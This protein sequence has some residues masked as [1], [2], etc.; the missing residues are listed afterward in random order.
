MSEPVRLVHVITRLDL[1]GAQQNTLHCVAH[2]DR[3]RFRVGLIAGAGGRLD[4]EARAIADADVDL[5]PWLRHPVAPVADVLAVLR[6]RERF[7]RGRID[8]VHTHSSKAGIVGRLAARLAGVPA[9]VHTVHGWSF[10]DTQPWPV[11]AAYVAL[12]RLAARWTH[13][14]VVVSSLNRDKGLSLGIGSEERYRTVHSGIRADDFR[15]PRG[16]RDAMRA[17]LGYGPDDRVVGTVGNLKAQKAPLDWI[18]AA[19][20]ARERDDRL[21]F[22]LVGDGPLRAESEAL[23]ARRGLGDRV[24]FLGWRDDVADLLQA[25]DVFLLTSRFEGLPRSVLQAM[26]AG[27]PV[28]A[29]AVDGTPEVVIDGETGVLVAPGD[30]RAAAEAVVRVAEDRNLADRLRSGASRRLGEGFDIDRMVV[31]LETMYLEILDTT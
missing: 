3:A 2:H 16:V 25:M 13:R 8:V 12:E 20:I 14:L 18:E 27:V 19:A 30:P 17:R 11:R 24:R 6:L 26:A 7:R 21:R 23:A 9:L 15:R 22:F 28:V 5:V 4:P 29:T 31:D 1:G 10:N